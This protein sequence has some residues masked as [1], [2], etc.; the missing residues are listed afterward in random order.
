MAALGLSFCGKIP[1][2]G[3]FQ[4]GSYRYRTPIEG[5]YIPYRSR[6][7]ALYTPNST[8]VV[9]FDQSLLG[10]SFVFASRPPGRS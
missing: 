9:S 2:L 3:H 8:P 5:L 7:E 1:D 6:K 4:V 10:L